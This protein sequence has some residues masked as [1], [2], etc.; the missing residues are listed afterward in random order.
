MKRLMTLKQQ[1]EKTSIIEDN[2]RN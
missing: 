2:Q 1:R